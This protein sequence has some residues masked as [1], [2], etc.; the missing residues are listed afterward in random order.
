MGKV[1]VALIVVVVVMV[2]LGLLLWLAPDVK[3]VYVETDLPGLPLP[4]GAK[5][6][7]P[8]IGWRVVDGTAAISGRAG[9]WY[10]CGCWEYTDKRAWKVEDCE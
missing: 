1:E 10:P 4:E 7:L 8:G 9:L 3:Q 5:V 2:V 6:E